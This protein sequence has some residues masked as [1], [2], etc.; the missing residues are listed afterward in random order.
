M[1]A[2]PRT[3][4]AFAAQRSAEPVTFRDRSETRSDARRENRQRVAT[5]LTNRD[6]TLLPPPGLT[7]AALN[8]WRT[9]APDSVVTTI[10]GRTTVRRGDAPPWLSLVVYRSSA[11]FRPRRMLFTLNDG[12]TTKS[13][14]RSPSA[15]R[16]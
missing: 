5:D 10:E 11:R 12:T 8:Q 3:R 16:S 9:Q 4:L 15:D 6:L 13:F 1:G 14:L 7:G 2:R